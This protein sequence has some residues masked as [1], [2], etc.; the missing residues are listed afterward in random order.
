MY[1]S[2]NAMVVS[3]L[4][5]KNFTEWLLFANSLNC[6]SPCRGRVILRNLYD[7][8]IRN[9][10]T[11]LE[12]DFNSCGDFVPYSGLRIEIRWQLIMV[13]FV[14]FVTVKA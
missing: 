3:Q 6:N 2:A 13:L 11:F 1:L 14:A 8:W 7:V 4:S 10:W 5:S 12:E 9:I